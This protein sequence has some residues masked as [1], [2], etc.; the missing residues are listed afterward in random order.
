MRMNETERAREGGHADLLGPEG[1]DT[2]CPSVL[3]VRFGHLTHFSCR[4]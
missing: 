2:R 3:P 1:N 4:G